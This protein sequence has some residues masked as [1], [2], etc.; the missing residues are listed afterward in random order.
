MKLA[1]PACS[2]AFTPKMTLY[3]AS[4]Y[5]FEFNRL[6]EQRYFLCSRCSRQAVHGTEA[7]RRAVRALLNFAAS[8]V[9]GGH[10]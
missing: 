7:G 1:C 2:R 10:E 4:V 8:Q 9:D 6:A 5:M 3:S